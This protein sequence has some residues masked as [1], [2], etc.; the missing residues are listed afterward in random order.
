MEIERKCLHFLVSE[1]ENAICSMETYERR[2]VSKL[3]DKG[4]IRV[5]NL[6]KVKEP[7]NTLAELWI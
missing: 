6:Y 7:Y 4:S 2:T 3:K 1:L 5:H